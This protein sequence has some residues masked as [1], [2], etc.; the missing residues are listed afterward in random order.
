MRAA[1]A[2]GVQPS[3]PAASGGAAG[4]PPGVAW[5]LL[6]KDFS[7]AAKVGSDTAEN[8]SSELPATYATFPPPTQPP[9]GLNESHGRG[10]EPAQEQDVVLAHC[11]REIRPRLSYHLQKKYYYC[12]FVCSFSNAVAIFFQKLILLNVVI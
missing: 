7:L 1:S 4:R 8:R 9:L 3:V 2:S 10:Q 6:C 11:G 5:A 12:F